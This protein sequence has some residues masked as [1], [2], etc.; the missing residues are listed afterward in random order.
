MSDDE[1]FRHALGEYAT[2]VTVITFLNHDGAAI[3][4]T[5]N[6]FTSL[7]LQPPL[8][9]WCLDN[10]SEWYS[11]MK[12]G[13]SFAINV[14]ASDQRDIAER[15]AEL[16]P[17]RFDGILTE[18]GLADLPLVKNAL[19]TFECVVEET[20]E[21]GDHLIIIGRVAQFQSGDGSPLIFQR[22]A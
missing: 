3:G 19:A 22:G 6:S 15:F 16:H 11:Q 5:V 14:L 12:P 8:I 2:G 17:D 9:L 18:S 4:L 13:L 1:R 10:L 20:H 21:G 7:S